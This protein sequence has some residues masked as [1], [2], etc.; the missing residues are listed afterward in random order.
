MTK[1]KGLNRLSMQDIERLLQQAVFDSVVEC[2]Y[3]QFQ[4][5]ADYRVC[6]ECSRENPLRLLGLI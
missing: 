6:P 1:S 4:L 3:C 2:P 5:E